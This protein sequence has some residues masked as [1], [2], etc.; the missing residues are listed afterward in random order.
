ML[1]VSLN[2]TFPSFQYFHLNYCKTDLSVF[3]EGMIDGYCF[4]GFFI[5]AFVCCQVEVFNSVFVFR[6]RCL[7]LCLCSG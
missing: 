3:V 6:L 7:T 2:K 5:D 1:S 4:M